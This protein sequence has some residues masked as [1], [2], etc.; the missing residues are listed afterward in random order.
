M[1]EV[2]G[3]AGGF[4][5]SGLLWAGCALNDG[6]GAVALLV[7]GLV[8]AY[9]PF[10][11]VLV[12]H[13]AALLVPAHRGRGFDDLPIAERV[14]VTGEVIGQI[15]RG[16]GDPGADDELQPGILQTGEVHR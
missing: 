7:E 1:V 10:P 11:R 9:E 3:L 16:F 13:P 5:E 4:E 2:G 8:V 6:Q 12:D 15:V 14:A